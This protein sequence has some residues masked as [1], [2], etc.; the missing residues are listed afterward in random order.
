MIYRLS[1]YLTEL[2]IEAGSIEK[3]DRNIY[4]YGIEIIAV[5]ALN[6]IT[7]IVI[8]YAMSMLLDC[9]IFLLLFMPL[10]SYAGGYHNSSFIKCYFLSCS[11][12]VISLIGMSYI[13]IDVKHIYMLL[14]VCIPCLYIWKVAPIE[15]KNKPM[16]IEETKKNRLKTR[17]LVLLYL[18]VGNLA[19]VFESFLIVKII[20]S[21]LWITMVLMIIEIEYSWNRKKR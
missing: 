17:I 1:E 9:V 21:A 20:I 12:I 14:I 18:A 5:M 19:F 6:V 10:R 4:R 11:I 7:I 16:T 2:L 8:G 13:N 15:N 3:K